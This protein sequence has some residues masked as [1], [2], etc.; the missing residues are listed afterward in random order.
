MTG[1]TFRS[2]GTNAPGDNGASS[3]GSEGLLP[4]LTGGKV[5]A[6]PEGKHAVTV[7]SSAVSNV[8]VTK[9]PTKSP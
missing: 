4:E 9:R 1:L 7:N 8:N 5:V 2:I 3:L 6:P